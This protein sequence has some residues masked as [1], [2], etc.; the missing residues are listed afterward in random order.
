MPKQRSNTS[1]H[2]VV[3]KLNV[4]E[5]CSFKEKKLTS[6]C[7]MVSQLKRFPEHSEKVFKI[8]E[9]KKIIGVMRIF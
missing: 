6:V 9:E 4:G 1:V 7:V 2:A 5:S 3:G 8:K